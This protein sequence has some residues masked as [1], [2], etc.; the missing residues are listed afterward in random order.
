MI[1]ASFNN[2]LEED[3]VLANGYNKPKRK[4][5]LGFNYKMN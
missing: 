1:N 2:A 3:Y 5:F 4:V